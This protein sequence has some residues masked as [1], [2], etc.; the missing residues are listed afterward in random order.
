M[1]LKK[2]QEL[3]LVIIIILLYGKHLR[4]RPDSNST[5][6]F[7]TKIK[8]CIYDEPHNDYLYTIEW[9]ELLSNL[10]ENYGFNNTNIYNKC[11]DQLN[12]SDYIGE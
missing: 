11:K 3:R 8:Y 7:D 5:S 10:I 2:K 4:F 6:K 12:I 9:V 1:P